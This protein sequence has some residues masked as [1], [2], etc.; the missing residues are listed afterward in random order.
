MCKASA[1]PSCHFRF[2][3]EWIDQEG[4]KEL[5]LKWWNEY[6]LD[7]NNVAL[8]WT[9][10]LKHLKQKIR[11]WARNYYGAKKKQKQML[12]REIHRLDI[13]QE[14]QDLSEEEYL[15]WATFKSQLDKI[16][17]EEE[18]YWKNRS[19]QQWLEAGDQ[20]TKFFHVVASH[21]SRKNRINAVEIDGLPTTNVGLMK[22]HAVDFYKNLL[23]Q[24]GVKYAHL[25]SQF[26]DSQDLI[27]PS[28]KKRIRNGNY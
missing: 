24:P 28:E 12:I 15:N 22:K 20:N 23:G 19:K 18:I 1:S 7:Y 10:K 3:P 9:N 8:S 2:E 11:G 5:L 17:L 14:T 4:F 26:W 27:T 25:D 6:P 16:Y 13:V 21:R